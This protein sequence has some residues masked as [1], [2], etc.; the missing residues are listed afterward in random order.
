MSFV[1][2]LTPEA[3]RH[4]LPCPTFEALETFKK[5]NVLRILGNSCLYV[6]FNRTVTRSLKKLQS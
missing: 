2:R 3:R 4:R 5:V 6:G 1:L